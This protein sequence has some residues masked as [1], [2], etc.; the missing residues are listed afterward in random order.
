MSTGLHRFVCMIVIMT[1]MA[2]QIACVS[3][4]CSTGYLGADQSS[5]SLAFVTGD[6]WIPLKKGQWRGICFHLMTSSWNVV[7]ICDNA[8]MCDWYSTIHHD[9]TIRNNTVYRHVIHYVISMCIPKLILRIFHH[10]TCNL[11]QLFP[12][13]LLMLDSMT[14]IHLRP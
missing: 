11:P 8:I 4:V 2:S 1:A 5:A 3:I 9:C 13:L 10:I 12:G 7:H 14:A 6:R